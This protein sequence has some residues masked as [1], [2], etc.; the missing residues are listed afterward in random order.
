M[1]D[2]DY[3]N[4]QRKRIAQNARYKKGGSKSRKCTLPQDFMTPAQLK[5]RNSEVS[6]WNLGAPM[7]WS[8]FVA[9]PDD[10]KRE[11][12]EL[13]RLGYNASNAKIAEMLGRNRPAMVREIQRL[14][15]NDTAQRHMS[16]E[17]EKVWERFC[18][19]EE[20][21]VADAAPCEAEKDSPEAGASSPVCS[22][23]PKHNEERLL[24]VLDELKAQ[25][26]AEATEGDTEWGSAEVESGKLYFSGNVEAIARKLTAFLGAGEYRVTVEFRAV[27]K[28]MTETEEE[29]F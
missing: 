17:E 25:K 7:K 24:A 11:Y 18:K 6:T 29:L 19:G 16:R 27:P 10:L 20:C 13:L 3:D 15:M 12:I 5:R 23:I 26:Q 21:H 4:L 1:N 28:P 14:G 8:A 9:M 22:D 2:F